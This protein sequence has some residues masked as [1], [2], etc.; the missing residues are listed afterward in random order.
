M[1]SHISS[2]RD[3]VAAKLEVRRLRRTMRQIR[4]RL[5]TETDPIDYYCGL[6][7]AATAGARLDQFC[8]QIDQWEMRGGCLAGR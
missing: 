8:V 5:L 4:A 6:V 7:D 3:Y 2:R 1:T